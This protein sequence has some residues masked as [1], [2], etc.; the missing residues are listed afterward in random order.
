MCHHVAF[1][2]EGHR[3]VVDGAYVGSIVCVS[4]LVREEF[5]QATE[6]LEASKLLRMFMLAIAAFS[7]CF[8]RFKEL[9]GN[10]RK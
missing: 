4:E 2:V 9:F 6:Y 1:L 5:V 8:N 10:I 7:L 3:A